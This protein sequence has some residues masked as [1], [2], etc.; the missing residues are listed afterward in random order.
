[1]LGVIAVNCQRRTN[2]DVYE[3]LELIP[4]HIIVRGKGR[5]V[6]LKIN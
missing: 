4:I 3:K 6:Q 2:I 5:L 1:M